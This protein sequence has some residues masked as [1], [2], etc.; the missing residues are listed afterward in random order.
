MPNVFSPNGDGQN[1]LFQL[2]KDQFDRCYDALTVRIY[3]R[4]GQNVYESDD[5]KFEWDGRDE[6]GNEM[7]EGTYYVVL[8]GYYGGNEVTN[9]F[10]LTLF[11]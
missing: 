8:Q 1:D 11:R 2:K 5:A 3:N 6:N 10:P 9:N 4:W 7:T